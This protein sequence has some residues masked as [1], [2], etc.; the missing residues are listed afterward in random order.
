VTPLKVVDD[1]RLGTFA[2]QLHRLNGWMVYCDGLRSGAR[3][4]FQGYRGS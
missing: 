3:A 4:S 1:R 2:S